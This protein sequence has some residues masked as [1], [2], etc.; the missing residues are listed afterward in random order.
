MS[1]LG[2]RPVDE[3][4]ERVAALLGPDEMP[5]LL[6]LRIGDKDVAGPNV[7]GR[8][9]KRATCKRLSAPFRIG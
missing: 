1:L 9:R 7:A 2:F 6:N 4:L 8:S 5:M 3:Y